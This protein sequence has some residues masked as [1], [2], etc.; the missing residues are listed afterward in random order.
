MKATS[1]AKRETYLN[2]IQNGNIKSKTVKVLY[3]IRVAG[4]RMNLTTDVLRERLKMPHQT[5]T[6]IL[7]NLLDLGMIKID[8]ENNVKVGSSTYS[9]YKYVESEEQQILYAELRQKEKF[10][11]WAR[12]GLEEFEQFLPDAVVDALKNESGLFK[13]MEQ[14]ISLITIFDNE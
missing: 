5:I 12:R 13:E 11:Q 1:Q 3:V 9:S 7:S 6:A 8:Q 4:E 2:Q 14:D 10:Y